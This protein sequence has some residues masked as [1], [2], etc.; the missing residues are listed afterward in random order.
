MLAISFD[1]RRGFLVAPMDNRGYECAEALQGAA[2][3]ALEK[4]YGKDLR[5]INILIVDNNKEVAR[6]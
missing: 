6:F 4:K 2:H 5:T 3:T 1:H